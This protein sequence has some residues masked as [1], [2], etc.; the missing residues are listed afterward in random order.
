MLP[1]D[2]PSK[3]GRRKTRKASGPDPYGHAPRCQR[4]GQPQARS[5]HNRVTGHNAQDHGRSAT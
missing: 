4:S 2:E 3:T 1:E 5:H